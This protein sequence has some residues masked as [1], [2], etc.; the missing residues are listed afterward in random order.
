M[1]TFTTHNFVKCMQ[2]ADVTFP[3]SKA[4]IMATLGDLECQVDYNEFKKAAEIVREMEPE[5]YENAAAF[6]CAYNAADTV[7][8]QKATNYWG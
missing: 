8:L 3:N 4:W 2:K 6:Y 5:D 7:R 1:Y